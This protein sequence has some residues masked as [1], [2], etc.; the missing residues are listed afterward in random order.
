MTTAITPKPTV[1]SLTQELAEANARLDEREALLDVLLTE[2]LT[3]KDFICTHIRMLCVASGGEIDLQILATKYGMNM[4]HIGHIDA[5]GQ[6][7]VAR[8]MLLRGPR[9]GTYRI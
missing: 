6:H 5:A 8:G 3:S 1:A 2:L 7:F 4:A 9:V